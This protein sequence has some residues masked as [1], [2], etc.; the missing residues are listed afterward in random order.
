M[1]TST[2]IKK[3]KLKKK[4]TIISGEEQ[5]ILTENSLSLSFLLFIYF[6]FETESSYVA[7]TGLELENLL[8]Q[9]PQVL[10]LQMHPTTPG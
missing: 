4:K 2:K 3:H 8:P 6:C 1:L 9:F 10:G 7:Q 5:K